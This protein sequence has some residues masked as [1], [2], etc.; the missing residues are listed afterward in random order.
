MTSTTHRH[1]DLKVGTEDRTKR[2]HRV[3]RTSSFRRRAK[4]LIS[5]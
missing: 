4:R 3:R 5:R 1:V 2:V